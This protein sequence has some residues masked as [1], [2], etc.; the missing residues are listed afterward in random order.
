[1]VCYSVHE[2]ILSEL[3]R[4]VLSHNMS[5]ANFFLPLVNARVIYA[6]AMIIYPLF[7]YQS[8]QCI[9]P[10]YSIF[11][12][13]ITILLKICLSILERT[14]LLSFKFFICSVSGLAAVT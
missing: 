6:W 9:I 14:F 3:E 5:M 8:I 12:T 13:L 2:R 10:V 7:I 4:K 11:Y 1:M